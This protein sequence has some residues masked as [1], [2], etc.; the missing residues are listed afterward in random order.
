MLLRLAAA[1]CCVALFASSPVKADEWNKKT[2]VTFKTP[3]ELP[4][5]VLPAGT[6][7]FKLLDVKS[8]RNIVQVWNAD[9]THV[10]AT[11]LTI[12]N[13]NM[14]PVESTILHFEERPRQEADAVRAWIYPADSFG[15]EFVYPKKQ[16][17]KL[18]ETAHVPVLTAEVTATEKPED[19]IKEPVATFTP[20]KVAS[21]APLTQPE[22]P[23]PPPIV[24]AGAAPSP[25]PEL[26]KTAS[27]L[28]LL[29]LAGFGSLGL[30][31]ALR[32]FGRRWG[33]L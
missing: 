30:A 8:N 18:A 19:M 20:E 13:Y 4:G 15:Q 33:T 28:P 22:T 21:E 17:A 31:G 26:P 25:A 1:F 9:E 24:W 10:Y 23:P 16:A 7:V 3:V 12:P 27:P 2:T 6:Y 29:L 11:I 32:A 5:I 14:S